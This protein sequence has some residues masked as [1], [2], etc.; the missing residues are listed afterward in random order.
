MTRIDY[1][2][3]FFNPALLISCASASLLTK[4]GSQ[5][6]IAMARPSNIGWPLSGKSYR[7]CNPQ[8]W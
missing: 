6:A 5:T 1:F 2:D 3:Y 7:L 8:P 4:Y